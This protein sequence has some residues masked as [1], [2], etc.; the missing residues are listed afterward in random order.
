MTSRLFV[1]LEIPDEIL[2][3]VITFRNE[4]YPDDKNVRWEKSDKLHITLKFLSDVENKIVPDIVRS[5]T[6]II[7]NQKSI[8]IEFD[9]FGLFRKNGKPSILWA[10]FK[11]NKQLEYMA[12]DLENILEKYGISKETRKFRPHLTL[13]RVRGNE[14]YDTLNEFPQYM[15]EDLNFNAEYITLYKS[16]L[17]PGGSIYTP[18]EKFELN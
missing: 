11:R 1:A 3:R 14:D 13:L 10:G 18:V 5:I 16:E 6:E 15:L 8:V 7:N 2:N 9:K 4:I 17:K 12:K